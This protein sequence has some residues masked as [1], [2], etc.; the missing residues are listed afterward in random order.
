MGELLEKELDYGDRLELAL[1]QNMRVGVK[2]PRAGHGEIGGDVA[3]SRYASFLEAA[4]VKR[5]KSVHQRSYVAFGC[6]LTPHV[7]FPRL[8]ISGS[9]ASAASPPQRG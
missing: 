9:A 8:T 3:F 4:I 7:L 5:A 1:E 6:E 2:V